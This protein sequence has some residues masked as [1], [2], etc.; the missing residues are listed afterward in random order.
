[1][2][3]YLLLMQILEKAH[4]FYFREFIM[5]IINMFGQ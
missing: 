5:H 4:K 1:M 3:V 2:Q